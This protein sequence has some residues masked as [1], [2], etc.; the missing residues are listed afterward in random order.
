[1]SY[2]YKAEQQ[3]YRQN[4]NTATTDVGAVIPTN[5]L[6]QIIQKM[7]SVGKVLAL[8]TRTAYKGGVTIPKNTVKLSLIHI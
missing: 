1:M 3:Q 6:N 7:E 4:A 8:V 2:H 5:V